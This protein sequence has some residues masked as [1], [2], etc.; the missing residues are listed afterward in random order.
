MNQVWWYIPLIPVL[1]GRSRRTAMIHM[2]SLSYE[3]GCI[4]ESRAGVLYVMY[5]VERVYSLKFNINIVTF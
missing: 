4:P 2:Y 1:R 3:G 5:P